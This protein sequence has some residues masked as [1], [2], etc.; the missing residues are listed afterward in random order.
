M[1]RFFHLGIGG[2]TLTPEGIAQIERALA[3][4]DWYR[5]GAY[6]WIIYASGSLDDWRDYLRKLPA[7]G[8]SA[9]FFLSEM[10][11]YSGYLNQAGWDWLKSKP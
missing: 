8:G 6:S 10:S 7:L 1:N 11:L 2:T 3:T 9:S 5:N 4:V